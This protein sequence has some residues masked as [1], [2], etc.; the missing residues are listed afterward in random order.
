MQKRSRLSTRRIAGASALLL[1]FLA[2]ALPVFAQI[3]RLSD[4][5]DRVKVRAVAERTE[6]VP[7]G[8]VPV[9][10]VLD[11]DP[12]WHT[13]TNDPKVPTALGDAS[14]YPI[15]V[16]GLAQTAADPRR[17]RALGLSMSLGV[18]AFWLV[19]GGMMATVSGFSAVNQLFQYPAFTIGV[20]VFIA[21]MAVGMCGLFSLRLPQFVY[22]I[23]PGHDTFGGSFVFGIMTAVLSTPC[24][25]PFMG[26]ALGWA[27]TQSRGITMATFGAIGIGM[28]LPYLVLTLRPA[29]VRKL[30]RT[31]PGSVLVEE[32]M[33]LLMLAAAAFFI[34][35]GV[36]ALAVSPGEPP[37]QFYWWPVMLFGAAAGG[38]LAWRSLRVARTRLARSV[39]AGLGVLMLAVAMFG[40]VRLTAGDPI[41]WVYYTPERFEQAV[42]QRRAILMDF[43]AEWCLNCKALEESVLR[44]P[45]VI[46]RIETGS[47]V[48]MKVDLT[49]GGND[50]GNAMLARMDRRTIPLLVIFGADGQPHFKSDFYTVEQ[51]VEALDTVAPSGVARNDKHA[52]STHAAHNWPHWRGPLFTGVAPHATPPLQWSENKNILWKTSLP[53]KGHSTPVVWGDRV[54]VTTAVP[55]GE[56]LD[57]IYSTA[58]GTHGGVPVTHYHRFIVIALDRCSGAIV[59]QNTVRLE[60]PHEGGY[61]TGSLASN[62]AVTDGTSVFAFF[63]SYGLYRLN[64][65]GGLQWKN[66]LGRMQTK[67]GHGEGSSPVLYDDVLVVN[68]DHEGHSFLAAFDKNTGKR[69]WKTD[70]DEPT[71]WSSP[72][73]AFQDFAP[74][75][76]V[77]GTRRIRG[78]NIYD[79]SVIWECGGLSD[80]VVASPVSGNGVVVAGSSYNFQVMLAIRLDGA[81]GDVTGS[82]QVVWMRRHGTP[83]VPSP[84]LYDG[85]VYYLRHYQG[86]LSRID[87][88]TGAD[89]G[90]PFRFDGIR[91]V[92]ASPVAAAG[93]IY[94]TGLN[95][96]TLVISSEAKPELLALN[97]LNDRF[98]ASAAMA[99]GQLFLRGES[100]LYCIEEEG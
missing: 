96:A 32:V 52:A 59:W 41:A 17:R 33:G 27:I 36:T 3:P 91:D 24:T 90:G 25:A 76:I 13:H 64:W 98:S 65:D 61:H 5:R 18:V 12:N 97:H 86:M 75:V 9:A 34:G 93:R 50:A 14:L 37:S 70:R 57:P 83:Y 16:I 84:L 35:V 92:F 19:L 15:K 94:I 89:A 62:S 51:V 100:Y 74:Q 67:H 6:G 81:R 78:Y 73:V 4:S 85:F 29:L 10:V 99:G 66:D 11:H 63:G 46:E 72:I 26:A 39:L 23:S 28:A 44:H 82:G 31:G 2:H 38:W 20:G 88:L 95:G 48:P 53:G 43:T 45:A 77:N 79:G 58:P 54:F 47:I 30:P 21:A 69:L 1:C 55:F 22:A 8:D 42:A 7:G 87:V 68:W 49:S 56:K 71:S 60:L 80:N 40:G